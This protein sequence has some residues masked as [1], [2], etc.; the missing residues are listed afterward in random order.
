MHGSPQRLHPGFA[1]WSLPALCAACVLAYLGG[2]S[3]G[4]QFDDFQ[5]IVD[6]DAL[7]GLATRTHHWL[8]VALSTNSG[9][10]RRPISMLSFGLNVDWFGMNPV[11]FK[12]VNLGIHLL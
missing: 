4:F 3:G 8:R 9:P 12:L 2:L 10:L 5:V 7:R 1:L 6:N 11:A